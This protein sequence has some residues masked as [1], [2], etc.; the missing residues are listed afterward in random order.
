MLRRGEQRQEA[1]GEI[2]LAQHHASHHP[3]PFPV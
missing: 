2:P 3:P 1:A